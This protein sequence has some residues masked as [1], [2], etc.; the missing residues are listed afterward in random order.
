VQYWRSFEALEAY[1]QSKTAAHLPA[2]RAFQQSIGTNG[3]VGIWHETY[4]I[5]SGAYENVYVNMP[6]FG[7]G[8]AGTLRDAKDARRDA[9]GRMAAAA[10]GP[11]E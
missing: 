9:R 2:W 3:D 5:K 10:T 1:A 8:A 6:P 4:V 7:L 11:A